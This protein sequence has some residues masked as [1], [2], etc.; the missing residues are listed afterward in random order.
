MKLNNLTKE[1]RG[2]WGLKIEFKESNLKI[3]F[4]KSRL[5]TEFE[6]SQFFRVNRG[7]QV[8]NL[9]LEVNFGASVD[10]RCVFFMVRFRLWDDKIVR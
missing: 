8:G 1:A 9:H 2:D 10:D 6:E 3:E 5:K 4:K 7:A